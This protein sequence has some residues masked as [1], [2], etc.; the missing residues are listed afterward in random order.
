MAPRSAA[1]ARPHGGAS[2]L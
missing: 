1:S 2:E